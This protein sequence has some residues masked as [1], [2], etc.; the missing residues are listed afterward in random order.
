MEETES[1]SGRKERRWPGAV[2]HVC[3]PSTLGGQVGRII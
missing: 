2:A 3:N 1:G